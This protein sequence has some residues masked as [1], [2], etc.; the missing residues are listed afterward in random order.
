MFKHL[1]ATTR[2]PWF[3]C[4]DLG[5]ALIACGL[6]YLTPAGMPWTLPL[7]LGLAPWVVRFLFSGR[8]TRRTPFDWPLALFLVTAVVSVWAA[9]DRAFAWQKFWWIVGGILLFYS[10]AN[11]RALWPRQGP[12]AADWRLWGITG[13]GLVLALY[14]MA[15]HD[16]PGAPVPV[17]PLGRRVQQLLPDLPGHRLNAN[18]AG[19]L[20][21]FVI[22]F[23]ASLIL[24]AP[25]LPRRPRLW[26]M[27]AFLSL[28]VILLALLLSYSRGA[29][30]ALAAAAVLYLL[31][32]AAGRLSQLTI[33]HS[34]PRSPFSVP[35]FPFSVFH[36]QLLL[37]GACLAL[38]VGLPLL[39]LWLWP[40]GRSAMTHTWQ[41]FVTT[42]LNRLALWR[43]GLVLASDYPFTGGGLG[44]FMMLYST[45]SLLLHVGHSFHA[46]NLF[47]DVALEQGLPA[48]LLLSWT[49]LLLGAALLR[50]LRPSPPAPATT[51]APALGAAAFSLLTILLHGLVDDAFY[52]SRA[53]L[54]LFVP[55]AF[56]VPRPP[57]RRRTVDN[58][59]RTVAPDLIRG[60]WWWV[61][62]LVGLAGLLFWGRSSLIGAWYANLGAVAQSRAELAAYDWRQW[63]IQ[64][65]IRQS[66]DLQPAV[67]YFEQA[68]AANPNQA[69]AH[70]RLG[71]IALSRADYAAAL[72]HLQQAYRLAPWDNATRQWLGEAYIVNGRIPEGAALWQTVI[73]NN[74]Q[75]SHRLYWYGQLDDPQR[76]AWVQEAIALTR[77]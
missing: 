71:L 72:T 33:Q 1:S 51:Y 35:R 36:R 47:L 68:L 58:G 56:A 21:A 59:R 63:G 69:T 48:L 60:G 5:C 4:F 66:V 45:Y 3:A 62:L 30:L 39:L 13:F 53:L 12:A 28:A 65:N 6:W 11:A 73:T 44:S 70:R 17:E 46:H 26:Q 61:L 37:F 40:D 14:F 24:S 74:G 27:A 8:L 10:L 34:L 16:W 19:G 25:D 29:W 76:L 75:L 55:L 57:R 31:W 50:W 15:T 9:Y 20:L 41:S 23:T 7:T 67:T 77:P 32:Q 49:W 43:G 18:V 52:G 22:P 2:H 54:L 38:A 64:D 42:D